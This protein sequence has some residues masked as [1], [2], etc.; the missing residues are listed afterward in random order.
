[1]VIDRSG[2][3]KMTYAVGI[4]WEEKAQME[5]IWFDDKFAGK[6]VGRYDHHSYPMIQMLAQGKMKHE[7]FLDPKNLSYDEISWSMTIENLNHALYLGEIK[8]QKI[9]QEKQVQ[10]KV[11]KE[12]KRRRPHDPEMDICFGTMRSKDGLCI[13][14]YKILCFLI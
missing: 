10:P 9:V 14:C 2:N 12:K 13:N 11:E 1:M 4:I 7:S 6:F 8:G 5:G 3:G